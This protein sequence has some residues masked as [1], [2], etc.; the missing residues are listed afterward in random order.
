MRER[1]HPIA[2]RSMHLVPILRGLGIDLQ[3]HRELQIRMRGIYHHLAHHFDRRRD[4]GI[5]YLEHQFVM[6]LQKPSST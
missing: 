1:F 6:D 4:L 5:R 2:L 3:W